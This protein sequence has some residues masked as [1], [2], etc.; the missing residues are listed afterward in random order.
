MSDPANARRSAGM[1]VVRTMGGKTAIPRDGACIGYSP[2]RMIR[3]AAWVHPRP[4]G[5]FFTL[6]SS[7]RD[8]TEAE[9][10]VVVL[11]GLFAVGV[12]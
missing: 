9:V 3:K 1:I 10:T 11:L 8:A 6:S 2:L 4:L 5:A 12:D 7:S